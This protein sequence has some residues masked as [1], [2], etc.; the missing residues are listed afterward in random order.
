MNGWER[1]PD[2]TEPAFEA[3]KVYLEMHERSLQKVSAEL[4]KSRQLINRWASRY[5]W[6]SRAREWDNALLDD[7]HE[8]I[9]R[10]IARRLIKQWRQSIALQDKSFDEIVRLLESKPRSLK[11]LTELYNSAADRQWALVDRA[12][13]GEL[14]NDIR[15]TIED[16]GGDDVEHR[17]EN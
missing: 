9:K 2:E 4:S 17:Q 10:E 15:I 1:L 14:D 6:K 3:F 12:G 5:D 13:V 8:T 16:A 11:T 7:V